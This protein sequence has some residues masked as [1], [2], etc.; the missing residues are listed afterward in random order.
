MSKYVKTA[1]CVSPGHPDKMA[2]Q[3]A[4][5]CAK[6]MRELGAR[7]TAIEVMGGHGTLV[8]MGESDY[9]DDDEIL[10]DKVEQYAVE[11]I[12]RNCTDKMLDGA[13]YDFVY[14]FERQSPE[15]ARGVDKTEAETGAGDQ[16]I[17]TGYWFNTSDGMPIEH[18]LAKSLCRFLY[19]K[20][21]RDGKTQVSFCEETQ[22]IETIVVSWCG[23][24]QDRLAG[25]VYKW[26]E[27]HKAMMPWAP[28]SIDLVINPAGDWAVGGFDADTGLTGRKLAVDFYGANVPLGGGNL[29]GKDF[30]KVDVS[31]NLY[32]RHLAEQGKQDG[33]V[34]HISIGWAIGDPNPV[35]VD[36]NFDRGLTTKDITVNDA[37]EWCEKN[38]DVMELAKWGI[39]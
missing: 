2:D 30:S 8:F 17:T 4:A 14:C 15:I 19:D 16:G 10:S 22:T 3:L 12:N 27:E 31:G 33:K 34:A 25:A 5:Y 20:W 32:A 28:E 26:L 1:E 38:V 11:L 13:S 18:S 36:A 29:H 39:K 35:A 37:I 7:R 6:T 24:S 9:Q 21:H 23:V